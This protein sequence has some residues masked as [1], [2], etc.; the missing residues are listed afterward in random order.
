[1]RSAFSR[2]SGLVPWSFAVPIAALLILAL[3]W[4]SKPGTAALVVVAALLTAAVLTSVH[5]AEVI[6][7]RAGEPLG[8]SSPSR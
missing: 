2:I 1:M 8:S 3:T 6:A 4:G 7:H 5:H